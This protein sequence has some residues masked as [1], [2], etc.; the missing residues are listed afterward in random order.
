MSDKIEETYRCNKCNLVKDRSHFYFRKN[1]KLSNSSCKECVSLIRKDHY[2]KHKPQILEERKE[3]RQENQEKIAE[4]QKTYRIDNLDYL[5]ELG[6]IYYQ[7]NRDHIKEYHQVYR[8][9]NK[10]KLK[11]YYED[12]KELLNENHRAYCKDNRNSINEWQRGRWRNDPAFRLRANIS[13]SVN[14]S[15][16]KNGSS[17]NG[18]SIV[19]YFDYT[20]SELKEHLERQFESWMTWDNQG[21]YNFEIWDDNDPTTWTWQL[22]HIIPQSDLPYTSMTEDNFKKCW[23]IENLRPLSAKQNIIDGA[24]R[25]RHNKR[26]IGNE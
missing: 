11:K 10:D 8:E 13:R 6:V 23:A 24:S 25:A 19:Q 17:K 16:Q 3:Y 5:K 20:F 1:G 4:Y 9:E 15:L 7:D 22:D 12:N 18:Q 21:S 26:K 14:I 2:K